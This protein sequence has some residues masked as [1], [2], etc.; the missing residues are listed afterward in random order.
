M[1]GKELNKGDFEQNINAIETYRSGVNPTMSCKGHLTKCWVNTQPIKEVLPSPLAGEVR[2]SR[3]EGVIVR[4]FTPGCHPELDSGSSRY[5]NKMLKQV[6]RDDIRGFTLIELLVVVLIIGIL[7]AV[8]LPQYQ[9]AVAKA[10]ATE[11]LT[12]VRTYQ[13]ALDLEML[14]GISTGICVGDWQPEVGYSLEQYG[15]VFDYYFGNG[16]GGPDIC[17]FEANN[18]EPAMCIITMSVGEKVSFSFDKYEGSNKW[19]G[20]CSGVDTDGIALCQAFEQAGM[21]D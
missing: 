21:L 11:M 18:E 14:K 20:T 1:L 16:T 10:R 6:Q 19:T 13:K 12:M 2:R 7:A 17:C 9:K 15:K 3:D 4:R 8:A 5:N